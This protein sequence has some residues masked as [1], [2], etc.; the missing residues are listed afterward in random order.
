MLLH[1]VLPVDEQWDDGSPPGPL[2]LCTTTAAFRVTE[3][4]ALVLILKTMESH[5]ACGSLLWQEIGRYFLWSHRCFCPSDENRTKYLVWG[6]VSPKKTSF[7]KARSKE[8]SAFLA[9]DRNEI[10]VDPRPSPAAVGEF[11]D[12][13]RGRPRRCFLRN[14]AC[15]KPSKGHLSLFSWFIEN[16]PQQASFGA[17]RGEL[18]RPLVSQPKGGWNAS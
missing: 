10:V 16:F 2:H 11:V 6:V 13:E 8:C 1:V 14:L 9:E 5:T 12:V 3:R 4:P 17:R 18:N 7:A 15:Q